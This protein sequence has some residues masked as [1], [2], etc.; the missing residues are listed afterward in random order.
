[1]VKVEKKIRVHKNDRFLETRT[2]S[3]TGPKR[4]SFGKI[5]AEKIV[6]EAYEPRS[7]FLTV[8]SLKEF[9][10]VFSLF[11]FSSRNIPLLILMILILPVGLSSDQYYLRVEYPK[12]CFAE[13]YF[14]QRDL[15][16][17]GAMR[18]CDPSQTIYANPGE[19]MEVSFTVKVINN[20]GGAW[21]TPVV[22]T[23]SWTRGNFT[24]IASDAPSGESIQTLHFT[25]KA[26][27]T[28]GTYYIGIFTGWMYNCE[29]VASND[30]PPQF[31]D[32]DDVWDMGQSDWESIISTGYATRYNQPGRAI[33]IVVSSAVEPSKPLAC[34]LGTVFFPRGAI[35]DH[36]SVKYV[37]D[38]NPDSGWNIDP[39]FNDANWFDGRTPIG[40]GMW[41]DRFIRTEVL[42]ND[43]YVRKIFPIDKIPKNA[44]LSIASD[45]GAEVWINGKKVLNDLNSAHGPSYWNYKLNVTNQLV[46]GEN[47]LAV[48]VKNI[49]ING[50]CY[51]DFELIFQE[52]S[53]NEVIFS[54]VKGRFNPDGGFSNSYVDDTFYATSILKTLDSIDILDREKIAFWIVSHRFVYGDFGGCITWQDTAVETINN[55]GL[56]LDDESTERLIKILIGWRAEDGSWGKNLWDTWSV[57][58]AL[59]SLNALNRIKDW[60]KT[61]NFIKSLQGGD[62][63]F[64]NRPGETTWLRFTFYAIRSLQLLN[65][66]DSIDKD[67]VVEFIMSCYKNEGFSDRP[68]YG[69]WVEPTYWAIESLG[70]LNSLDKVNSETVSDKVLSWLGEKGS[71]GYLYGDY[72]VVMTLKILNKLNKLDKA[73]TIN[74]VMEFQNPVDNGFK[75]GS[76][77]YDTEHAIRILVNIGSLDDLDKEKIKRYVL[78]LQF[79]YWSTGD[80]HSAI[81]SLKTLNALQEVDAEKVTNELLKH[82]LSDGGFGGDE[83]YKESNLWETYLAI[84]TLYMLNRLSVINKEKV[85]NYILSLKNHDGSFSYSKSEKSYE[86]ATPLA[87]ITLTLLGEVQKIDEKTIN[88]IIKNQQQDGDF[89][90][91]QKTYLSLVALR[92]LGRLNE[93][94]LAKAVNYVLSLQN[95]DGGFGNWKGDV[96]SWLDSTDYGTGV[97]KI[98]LNAKSDYFVSV[99]SSYGVPTG[100]GW[101]QLGSIVTISISPSVIDHGN[102]TKRIFKGWYED[103]SMMSDRQSF[104]ITVDK[105]KS[106][107]AR[108]D[109][110]YEVKVSS[111]RGTASGSGWYKAGTNATVTISPT[112]IDKDFFSHY[113]FEGW[114]VNGTIVSTSPTYSFV[115]NKPISL[116]ASWRTELKITNI[117]II[118]GPIMLI[119]VLAAVVLK[120]KGVQPPPPKKDIEN[121]IKKYEEYLDKLEQL[122]KEGK[123]SEQAYKKLREEYEKKLEELVEKLKK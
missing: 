63:G 108:W 60:S 50:P 122:K 76:R 66:T 110:E 101:Y 15:V 51:F 72:C 34:A 4:S 114:K 70:I 123:I 120:R 47:L 95:L 121:E 104:S 16:T 102:G 96:W 64:F 21:V 30:H 2:L 39:K 31:G 118:L 86:I 3:D 85:V 119:V 19:Y 62:G 28:I 98:T 12:G 49:G 59:A 41:S 14:P 71:T 25:L 44:L 56:K 6:Y 52:N 113:V 106:I 36:V 58:E 99:S 79:Y 68:E 48:H 61:V 20:R 65:A 69:E 9:R 92:D 83:S 82:Q 38:V 109:T 100:G 107:V 29:E 75:Y 88:W 55:L 73:K 24:C 67:K 93:T 80:I 13:I 35:S 26:P 40:S 17:S 117:L 27:T 11:H 18:I 1:M 74:N 57:V 7:N 105:P 22:G 45:D 81:Y 94:I 43:L 91:I 10:K 112:L 116:T 77:L 103:D 46:I 23:A 89:G 37:Y 8:K 97:L 115:V 111:D 33:R 90:D 5:F 42:F 84:D 54:F 32:G 87:V 53:L 78:S